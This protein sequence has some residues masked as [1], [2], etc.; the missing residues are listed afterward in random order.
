[1]WNIPT[2]LWVETLGPQLELLGLNGMEPLGG[3]ALLE[4]EV[5]GGGLLEF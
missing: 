5:T 1:M 2:D 4:E 3:G